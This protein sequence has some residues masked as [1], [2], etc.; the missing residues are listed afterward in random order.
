MG[1]SLRRNNAV[2]IVHAQGLVLDPMHKHR[3]CIRAEFRKL[4]GASTPG[5]AEGHFIVTV[6]HTRSGTSNAGMKTKA[7]NAVEFKQDRGGTPI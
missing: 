5:H 2:E 3:T 1:V 6:N 7:C 4:A